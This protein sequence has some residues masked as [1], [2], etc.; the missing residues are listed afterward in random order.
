MVSATPTFR[1]YTLLVLRPT[2]EKQESR[3]FVGSMQGYSDFGG[4]DESP[5]RT[6]GG[7]RVSESGILHGSCTGFIV[8]STSYVSTEYINYLSAAHV[9]IPFVSSEIMKC[10]L[11]K[12]LPDHP[13]DGAECSHGPAAR[14]A[15]RRAPEVR[16]RWN[17]KVERLLHNA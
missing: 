13:T 12:W 5:P 17:S 3:S 15:S 11:L 1:H 7:S 8:I 14:P 10:R 2:H 6:R 16:G 9:V 4:R